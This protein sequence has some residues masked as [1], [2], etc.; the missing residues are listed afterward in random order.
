MSPREQSREVELVTESGTAYMHG[1]LP[2]RS[3]ELLRMEQ[4]ARENRF[5]I[6]G[7]LAG[8]FCY[9][10]ARIM[11]ARR[12]FEMGSGYGYSTAWFAR[13]VQEN[14][15]GRVHHVVWN[16]GLSRRARLCLERMGLGTLVEY[17]VSEAVAALKDTD[18]VF[19][20]IFC[21]IV[22]EQYPEALPVITEKLRPGGVLIADNAWWF[23]R[24]VD[25][26]DQS[27]PTEGMRVFT[28]QLVKD[29]SW[30][31]TFVPMR[32]GLLVAYRNGL[33]PEP[34]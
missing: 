13:A 2:S 17:R 11:G 1:L 24:V 32:D 7:P 19:D 3:P 12:I 22:K 23:G 30:V 20:I 34:R 25:E 18:E 28:Q 27:P 33:D 4:F 16:E 8:Q 9:Q 15:G 31:V 21:D 10:L 6:I 26:A 29:P 5:P 14:G